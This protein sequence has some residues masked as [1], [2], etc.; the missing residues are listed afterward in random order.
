MRGDEVLCLADEKNRAGRGCGVERGW[1]WTGLDN[2]IT[3][4]PFL[5]A[6]SQMPE[7]HQAL[8]LRHTISE[9]ARLSLSSSRPR[10]AVPSTPLP[11]AVTVSADTAPPRPRAFRPVLSPRSQEA[12]TSRPTPSRGCARH[13]QSA[14]EA[15][16][17]PST[18]AR[19]YSTREPCYVSSL[20]Q[21]ISATAS[22]GPRSVVCW[23]RLHPA[24]LSRSQG[25]MRLRGLVPTAVP[26]HR[27]ASHHTTPPAQG[28]GQGQWPLAQG[29]GQ[30]W[31]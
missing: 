4:A 3:H 13:A 6:P 5:T 18:R 14:R 15:R 22:I 21:R 16:S 17:A 24:S 25:L 1:E 23:R 8:R 29:H 2:Q 9:R 30:Q 26:S 10:D 31:R 7:Q 11:L 28:Q 19:P 27:Q 20:P 12:C